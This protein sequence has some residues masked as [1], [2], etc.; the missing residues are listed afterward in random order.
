[1]FT[2]KELP[3]NF[4]RPRFDDAWCPPS[5]RTRG[6]P[7]TCHCWPRL[8]QWR[9]NLFWAIVHPLFC[10]LFCHLF[11]HRRRHSFYLARTTLDKAQTSVPPTTI[12]NNHH[13]QPPP[14]TS[15]NHHKHHHYVH[16]PPASV[17]STE[18][19]LARLS[20]VGLG[21][22]WTDPPDG[23]SLNVG[24]LGPGMTKCPD[25]SKAHNSSSNRSNTTK[26]SWSSSLLAASMSEAIPL[27]ALF[28]YSVRSVVYLATSEN[29]KH[30]R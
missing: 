16:S 19:F 15:T 1:M 24:N 26:G 21:V 13:Q 6:G 29:N 3:S 17:N 30:N 4:P 28:R 7:A 5:S 25:F 22:A 8:F 2:N 11:C 23:S 9:V 20:W 18:S 12:T 14:T 27:L 10:P